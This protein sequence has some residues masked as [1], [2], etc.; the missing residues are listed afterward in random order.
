M[1]T[2]KGKLAKQVTILPNVVFSAI[3]LPNYEKPIQLVGFVGK[4]PIKAINALKGELGTQVT[5]TGK[6]KKNPK[7]GQ[8]EIIVE[9]AK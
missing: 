2:Y 4:C 3:E 8:L 1:Q 6:M 5:I 9:G 7:T